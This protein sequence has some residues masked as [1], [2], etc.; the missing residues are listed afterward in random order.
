MAAQ[1]AAG[2][3]PPVIPPVAPPVA[4]NIL[5][6]TLLNTII[7]SFGQVCVLEDASYYEFY[8]V[9]YWK[10]NDIWEWFKLKAKIPVI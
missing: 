5:T 3:A 7:I 10:F 1:P 2:A 8:T 9:L 4:V 6:G